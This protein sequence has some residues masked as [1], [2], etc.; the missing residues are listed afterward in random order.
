[1]PPS[2]GRAPETLLALT[3]SLYLDILRRDG[4]GTSQSNYD[5]DTYNSI[6]TPSSI[7]LKKLL[8]MMRQ[9]IS[10][11]NQVI[12]DDF[13]VGPTVGRTW[14]D[15]RRGDVDVPRGPWNSAESVMEALVQRE[16][17]CL[18]KFTTFPQDC[19]QGIF[20]G[21]GCYHP[22][23]KAKLSVLQDFLKIHHHIIP[24][25]KGITGGIIWHNDL[26]TDNIFVDPD[27]PSQITSIIDW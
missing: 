16:T 3:R 13:A 20:G 17:A 1:M 8:V 4:Y 25:S 23:H 12:D 18:K 2:R 11:V 9:D 15:D 6:Q 21:P 7:S 10:F 26:H 5:E 19:Q 14:F 27:N 22:S 24:H